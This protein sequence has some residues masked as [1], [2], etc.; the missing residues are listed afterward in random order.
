MSDHS[1][2]DHGGRPRDDETGLPIQVSYEIS[3][4]NRPEFP[5]VKY[6][7]V[8]ALAGFYEWYLYKR[9]TMI[10]NLSGQEPTHWPQY[11]KYSMYWWWAMAGVFAV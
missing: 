8:L 6:T 4:W 7:L 2:P 9:P 5:Y 3:V 10:Q 1:G 11:R